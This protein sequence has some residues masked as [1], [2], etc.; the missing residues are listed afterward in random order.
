MQWGA[1]Q[2]GT[3]LHR[4]QQ[5]MGWPGITMPQGT[6]FT[7]APRLVAVPAARGVHAN[8]CCCCCCSRNPLPQ[9]AGMEATQFAETE[10][11]RTLEGL[12][13]HLFGEGA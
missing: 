11:K 6:C 2:E 13:Q 8:L 4:R 9:A 3:E 1:W 7:Y 12:A 10:L 5:R